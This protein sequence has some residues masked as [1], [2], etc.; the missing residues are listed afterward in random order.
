INHAWQTDALAPLAGCLSRYGLALGDV[1]FTWPFTTQ[2]ISDDYR[3]VRDGLYGRGPLAAVATALPP[4]VTR[5]R[6]AR[7]AAP[8]V[9]NT[10]IVPI[11]QF[12]PLATQLVSLSGREGA[13]LQLF[14]EQL[15]F[16]DFVVAGEMRS[17][18]FFPRDDPHSGE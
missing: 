1:A 17:P 7:D 13:E 5:L 15:E 14:V 4:T 16:I 6:D 8:G 11:E 10:K 2:S 3:R 9:D 18:Q 12:I